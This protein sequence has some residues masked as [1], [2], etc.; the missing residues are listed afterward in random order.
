MANTS[1]ME[2]L[3]LPAPGFILQNYNIGVGGQKVSLETFKEYPALL[4]VFICNHFP[5]VVHIR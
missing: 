2:K 4:V 1:T 3:G 5:Y